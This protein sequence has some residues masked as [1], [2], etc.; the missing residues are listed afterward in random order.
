GQHFTLYPGQQYQEYFDRLCAGGRQEDIPVGDILNSLGIDFDKAEVYAQASIG[1]VYRVE[2]NARELAVKIRY[3]GVEKRISTDFKVL[4]TLLWPVKFT[5]LKN[6]ALIPLLENLQEAFLEECDYEKEA[7]VQDSFSRLFGKENTVFVPELVA[8]N[9][10]AIVSNWVKGRTL[11]D[12]KVGVGAWFIDTYLH[13]V[14]KSLKHLKMLH[15]DPHPGN[16]LLVGGTSGSDGQAK[17]PEQLAVIDFGSV[18]HFS[19]EEA[20]AA[21]RLL[22][23]DYLH[24]DEMILDLMTLGLKEETV[25]AYRPVISDLAVILLEPFY[26]PGCYDFFNWRLQ[27][28]INTILSSKTWERP[29]A[30]PLKL[31]LLLRTLQGIYYYAR[32]NF[33][34]FNWQEAVRKYM[35]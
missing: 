28:K 32:V 20:E 34:S 16:F 15:A 4:K 7:R 8:Y 33:V 10:K 23:G 1:Q 21:L 9:K 26:H 30:I 12:A 11:T 35:R 19:S 2:T 25:E 31:L 24:E 3:T 6:N 13:F 17:M 22:L 14:I 27:Y 18:V 5:P 29:L